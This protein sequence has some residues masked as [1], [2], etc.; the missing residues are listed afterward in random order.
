MI[1][2]LDVEEVKGLFMFAR[3]ALR[4]LQGIEGVGAACQDEAVDGAF[5]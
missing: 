2:E 1:M 4:R 3:W 5:A